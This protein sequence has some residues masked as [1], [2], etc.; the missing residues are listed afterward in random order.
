MLDD[1]LT[2]MLVLC[3]EG[4][5]LESLQGHWLSRVRFFATF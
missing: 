1:V 2:A 3:V 4:A 5:W